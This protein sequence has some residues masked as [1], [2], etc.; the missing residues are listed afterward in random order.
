MQRSME[1]IKQIHFF[2]I[3]CVSKFPPA[4]RLIQ[5]KVLENRHEIASFKLNSICDNTWDC[6][7]LLLNAAEKRKFDKRSLF[8]RVLEVFWFVK[9]HLKSTLS[10]LCSI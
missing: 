3:T 5:M 7:L 1:M 10:T 8:F 4:Y 6:V 9:I 2:L